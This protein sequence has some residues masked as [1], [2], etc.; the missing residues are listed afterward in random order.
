MLW[1]THSGFNALLGGIYSTK[2]DALRQGPGPSIS[3]RLSIMPMQLGQEPQ[4]KEQVYEK[5]KTSKNE[6]EPTC[7]LRDQ[8]GVRQGWSQKPGEMGEESIGL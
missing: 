2:P 8:Q 3:N 7:D 1:L 4:A 5:P 6:N